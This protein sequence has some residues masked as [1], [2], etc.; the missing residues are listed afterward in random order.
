VH[1]TEELHGLNHLNSRLAWTEYLYIRYDQGRYEEALNAALEI[2]QRGQ[3]NQQEQ[4]PNIRS[5]YAMEDIAALCEKLGRVNDA[6]AWLRRALSDAI[7]VQSN[8]RST[9]HIFG[10]LQKLED[11]RYQEAVQNRPSRGLE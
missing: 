2:L 3:T 6:I 1:T 9:S 5:I 10:K 11:K 8:S 7:S 4:S